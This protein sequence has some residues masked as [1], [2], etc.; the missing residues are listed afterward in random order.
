MSDETR[1]SASASQSLPDAANLE[2]LRK[3]AKRRLIELR[4]TKPD[5]KLADAQLAIAREHGFP[6]WRALKS[7]IDAL[8]VEG[9]LFESATKGDL[10]TLT[11]LLDMHPD[12]LNARSQPYEHSLLHAAAQNGRLDVVDELLERGIDVNYREKGDNTYAMHWAAA[13]GHLPIVRRLA[14]AGGDVVGRGDDHELEVIGWASCW[15]D[16]DDAAHRSIVDFLISRGAKHHIFSAIALNLADEVRRIVADDPAALNR[17]MSRNEDHQL[18]LHFAV[19]KNRRDMVALLIELG[20]DPLGVDGSGNQAAIRATAP[21]V[22]H[23]IMEKIIGMTR[24]EIDSAA[25]GHRPPNVRPTDLLAALALRDFET[26]EQLWKENRETLERGGVLHL[27]AKRGDDSAVGWLLEHGANPNAYW[28]HWDAE[29]TPLHMAAWGGNV[30]V[31]RQLLEAGA[32]PTLRDSK[33]DGDALGW[34]EHFGRV[35]IVRFLRTR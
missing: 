9:Q 18:P 19:E 31:A 13:A 12:K 14:N 15:D 34:A 20:A 17:R 8:S 26:S 10:D 35:E 32:D 33:H 27:M 1:G 6:S 24:A 4:A 30:E 29:V 3:Q 5:A 2:W 7:Y 11:S 23:G 22:D 25:R 16:A 21:D 28:A